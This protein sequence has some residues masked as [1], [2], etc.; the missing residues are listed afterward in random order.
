L[1][2]RFDVHAKTAK[3]DLANL[4]ERGLIE[5][6]RTPRPGHYQLRRPLGKGPS[7]DGLAQMPEGSAPLSAPCQL[8]VSQLL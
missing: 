4:V 2:R 8:P 3:R 6:V 7:W 5:F 1:E